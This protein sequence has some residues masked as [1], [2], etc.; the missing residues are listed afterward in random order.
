MSHPLAVFNY[1]GSQIRTFETETGVLFVANDVC[2]ILGVDATQVRRLDDDEKGLHTIQ[3]PGGPQSVTVINESGLYS[4]T[5]TSR[6][7][8]AKKFKKWITSEVLP[9][10][11]KTG[12]YSM[13]P[14]EIMARGL[15]EAQKLLDHQTAQI[16]LLAPK[17]AVADRLASADGLMCLRNA[18]KALKIKEHEF[19]K[20]LQIN[21]WIY[22][23]QKG[24][25]EGYAARVPR[26][27]DHKVTPIPVDGDDERVSLQVMVTAE[28]LTKL[29]G[30][31][32]VKE[33]A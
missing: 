16:A 27:L 28:G 11:R 6:K 20:W 5:L 8:S 17:A 31:F 24:R 7:D 22:R 12:A 15:I 3:T 2:G 19:V 29:A 18:A 30:I 4:L 25:L 21:G 9:S 10:I 32:N 1:E 26:F 23:N 13:N 14:Q 33:A